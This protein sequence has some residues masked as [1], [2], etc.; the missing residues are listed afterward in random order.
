MPTESRWGNVNVAEALA[1]NLDHY[2]LLSIAIHANTTKDVD[3]WEGFIY[4]CFV[5]NYR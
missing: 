3:A 1:I 2:H 4:R 5:K